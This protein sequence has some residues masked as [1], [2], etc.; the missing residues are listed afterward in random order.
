MHVLADGHILA[1]YYI[2]GW[3]F[4]LIAWKV[5]CFFA[6]SACDLALVSWGFDAVWC[7]LLRAVLCRWGS[8][9]WRR[10]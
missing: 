2:M 9:G 4:T 5:F 8:P 7:A 6:V 3:W 10:T 1:E